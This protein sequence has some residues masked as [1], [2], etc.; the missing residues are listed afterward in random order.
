[1]SKD[2]YQ[3][4]RKADFICFTIIRHDLS[5]YDKVL[6]R[7]EKDITGFIEILRNSRNVIVSLHNLKDSMNRIRVNGDN[8]FLSKG[9]VLKKQLDFITHIRNKG[10]GHLDKNLLERGAQWI[11]QIFHEQSKDNHEFIIF[12]CYRAVMESAINSYLNEEDKQKVFDT[13]IDFMY[14]P[15]VELFF[16]F[17]SKIVKDSISWL[18][19][20]INIIK[21]EIFFHTNED[22]QELGVVAGKTNFN[23]N[24]HSEFNYS[25]EEARNKLIEAAK[26]M[27]ETG[28]DEKTMKFFEEVFLK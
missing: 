24:E 8:D 3:F 17:L 16:D 10:V 1:L 22:V 20:A 27:R 2:K 5:S 11:P 28:A 19:E 4:S 23:L 21:S 6:E 25:E 14:P 9:R 15:D 13:E 18:C 12:E 26:K 7:K